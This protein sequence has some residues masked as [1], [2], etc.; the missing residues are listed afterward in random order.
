MTTKT[1]PAAEQGVEVLIPLNRLKKSPHNARRT[2]HGEAAIAALAASIAH[3]GLLQNLV[4]QRLA[5]EFRGK[6]PSGVV[7]QSVAPLHLA[8]VCCDR[9]PSLLSLVQLAIANFQR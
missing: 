4:V 5:R 8:P 3:K 6:R 7:G 1:A 9:E 2:P